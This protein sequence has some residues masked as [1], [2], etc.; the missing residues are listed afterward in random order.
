MSSPNKL[1][2]WS[3]IV[4]AGAVAFTMSACG[5][6]PPEPSPTSSPTGAP[7]SEPTTEPTRTSPTAK[8]IETPKP[9]PS[10]TPYVVEAI[11]GAIS[12]ELADWEDG[13]NEYIRQDLIPQGIFNAEV[14]GIDTG[15]KN[16]PF[17][18]IKYTEKGEVKYR[19]ASSWD[20][21]KGKPSY[22]PQRPGR[23]N[24]SMAV[25]FP[26]VLGDPDKFKV[27]YLGMREDIV[28]Q[29]SILSYE[30]ERLDTSK[31]ELQL[32]DAGYWVPKTKA[33][34]TIAAPEP[35]KTLEVRYEVAKYKVNEQK[36]ALN[37]P[38]EG[39][40]LNVS[41]DMTSQA[42]FIGFLFTLDNGGK[43]EVFKYNGGIYFVETAADEAV[44][45]GRTKVIRG[46]NSGTISFEGEQIIFR[47]ASGQVQIL[48][49]PSGISRITG[50]ESFSR[51]PGV[52]LDATVII[53]SNTKF[54]LPV[55][56]ARP[57]STAVP[58]S[59]EI[60]P[61]MC[62][63]GIVTNGIL[64]QVP[65]VGVDGFI[66]DGNP[67]II[68]GYQGGDIVLIKTYRTNTGIV[69]PTVWK[70]LGKYVQEQPLGGV[71]PKC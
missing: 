40:R 60:A 27:K 57:A 16:H 23:Y 50:V 17:L 51:V 55:A 65:L 20:S 12:Q 5:V 24:G 7:T 46:A 52:S 11:G 56:T 3:K 64:G 47:P 66:L 26:I 31:G 9:L 48:N 22:S 59:T 68:V 10:A 58:R 61:A 13:L 8:P 35:T 62:K 34:A 37:L 63:T 39:A 70:V 42:D 14:I 69:N 67:I 36:I 33:T 6:K 1:R 71:P 45:T 21:A 15:D 53:D 32:L 54:V 19:F 30:V 2:D 28:G 38:V 41:F 49:R 44:P 29:G 25:S 43:I 4:A 18:A